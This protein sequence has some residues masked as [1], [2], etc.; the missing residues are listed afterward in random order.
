MD[1]NSPVPLAEVEVARGGSSMVL[2]DY[3]GGSI[4]NLMS[5]VVTGCGGRIAPE[6]PF[7]PLVDSEEVSRCRKLVLM[8]ID[9][10]GHD[11]LC[12][13][14]TGGALHRR[15]RGRITSV[16][17]S[18]TAAAV[19]TFLTG[20]APQQHG[21]TG[22]FMYLRELAGVFAILPGK[23]RCGGVTFSRSGIDPREVF[24][25]GPVFDALP[26][27]S[28]IVTPRRIAQSDY[29]LA[30]RGKAELRCFDSLDEFFLTT[31]KAVREPAKGLQFIYA[32]W[33][34]LDSLGHEYGIHSK[35]SLSHLGQIDERFGRF[36]RQLSGSDTLVVLTADHGMIDT[37]EDH[38]IE[39]ADHP[40]L[41]D[42]LLLAL[43]GERRAA[44]CYVRNNRADAFESYLDSELSHAMAWLTSRDLMGRGAFGW[45]EAHPRLAERIGDYVLLMKDR[46]V[47]SDWLPSESRFQ[48]IGV[49]GG[50]SESEM[51]VPV[52]T[53]F[54]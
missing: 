34:D 17:P 47:L 53:A 16:F 51:F 27:G 48:H 4:V 36:C 5:S 11:T 29:N 43:C 32:Y 39:L 46:Y 6:Y 49:H 52:V 44:Y 22:W 14:A 42:C 28:I 24:A 19:T 41:A 26:G 50:V 7:T 45:G 3:D 23:P 18:T 20:L 13:A 33:P 21:L 31:A 9:G 30:H 15:L 25:T 12:Q 2:P 54:L 38:A 40:E 37:D 8:V 10:L 1:G 35:E